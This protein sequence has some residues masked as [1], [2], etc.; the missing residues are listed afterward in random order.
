MMISMR[1]ARDALLHAVAVLTL[2]S[3]SPLNAQDVGA[4][5]SAVRDGMVRFHYSSRADVCGDGET[6]IGWHNT[7]LQFFGNWSSFNDGRDWR[8]RCFHGPLRV[9]ITRREGRSVALKVM[10]GPPRDDGERVTDLG[11]VPVAS[12]VRA[13]MQ[14]A[15]TEGSKAADR[16][17]LAAALADSA[18][19]WPDLLA[20]ARNGDRP[21]KVRQEARQWLAWLAGDHV[22]GPPPEGRGK[23]G[24]PEGSTKK[25]AAGEKTQAVFVLSQL[26]HEEGLPDLL[27]IARSHPDAEVRRSAL[28]WL[29]QSSDPRVLDLFEELLRRS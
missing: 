24:L 4:R 20:I 10:A 27:R 1:L 5:I 22:L 13:L 25:S 21:G 3:G 11:M 28:F 15:R 17:I 8:E 2:A 23:K 9:T 18:V 16:A 12:A 26:P 29:S 6:I 19:V 7:Q 14:I